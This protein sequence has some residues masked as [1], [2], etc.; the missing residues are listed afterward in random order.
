MSNK[1]SGA[2]FIGRNNEP[3]VQIQYDTDTGNAEQKVEIP[4][5]MGVMAELS[6]DTADSAT[7]AERKFLEF[8]GENFSKRM[9]AMKP[10]AKFRVKNTLT[11]DGE[12]S[13]DLAF[14][15]MDDFS[16]AAI[17]GKVEPL[18]KLLE[19]RSQIDNLLKFMDGRENAEEILQQVLGDDD[20]LKKLNS[21]G[22]K[23]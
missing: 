19:A 22:D 16:P 12:I 18:R 17:A 23:K 9:K 20:L 2:K 21:A 1:V 15:S 3:R 4:F 6:G 13:V 11:G 8:N 10:S 5:V 7:V 14:E